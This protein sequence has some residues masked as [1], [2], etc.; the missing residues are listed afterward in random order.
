VTVKLGPQRTKE[1]TDILSA[2]QYP[3]LGETSAR[4]IPLS[5]Y[6]SAGCA[7][8]PPAADTKRSSKLRRAAT[9]S[10]VLWEAP[11]LR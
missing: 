2:R 1:L 8:K 11:V 9:S 6:G 4:R 5:G 7:S 10:S 3:G